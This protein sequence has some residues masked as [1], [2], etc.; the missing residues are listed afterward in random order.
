VLLSETLPCSFAMME[1][2]LGSAL[3]IVR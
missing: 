3:S 2:F 1:G